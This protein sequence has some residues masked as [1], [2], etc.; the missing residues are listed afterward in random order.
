MLCLHHSEMDRWRLGSAK[1]FII[2]YSFMNRLIA[3]MTHCCFLRS[4]KPVSTTAL[5]KQGL[6]IPSLV[7]RI[8]IECYLDGFIDG[9]ADDIEACIF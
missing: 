2:V 4:G 9:I 5:W 1:F 7:E 3:P 8:K 6:D